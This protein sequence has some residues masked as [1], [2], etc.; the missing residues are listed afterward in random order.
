[1]EQQTCPCPSSRRAVPVPGAQPHR[2]GPDRVPGRCSRRREEASDVWVM[3]NT[4]SNSSRA[5]RS[6][7]SASVK[8]VSLCCYFLIAALLS[9]HPSVQPWP[10]VA[11]VLWWSGY[12]LQPT[13]SQP[14]PWLPRFSTHM[15]DM[16]QEGSDGPAAPHPHAALH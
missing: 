4:V 16:N 7:R 6:G 8:Q 15:W 5:S 12:D 13:G 3:V 9:G 2:V 1:M 11:V 10:R 14:R